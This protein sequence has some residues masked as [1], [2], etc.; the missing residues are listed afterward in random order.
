MIEE[1]DHVGVVVKDTKETAERF[2]SLFGFKV[3]E[4]QEFPEQ[5]FKSTL[6]SKEKV[7]IEL[8]EPVGTAGIIQ[9]FVQKNGYGLHHISLRVDDIEQEI[10]VLES[11]GAKP[12]NRKPTRITDTSEI[13]FLHPSS[14]A[15][16]LVELMERA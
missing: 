3:A 10:E 7:T 16:I 12:L 13:A 11:K 1:F 14:T 6:I 9:K 2:S 8:I 5:G 15:G 4:C